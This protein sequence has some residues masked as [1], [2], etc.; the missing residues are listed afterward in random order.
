MFAFSIAQKLP[1]SKNSATSNQE[2]LRTFK[3]KIF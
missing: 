2:K 1:D 3:L